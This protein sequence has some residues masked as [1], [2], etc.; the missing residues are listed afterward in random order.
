MSNRC[1]WITFAG[2]ARNACEC[3]CFVLVVCVCVCAQFDL[4]LSVCMCVCVGTLQHA[5]TPLQS[6][7]RRTD[8]RFWRFEQIDRLDDADNAAHPLVVCAALRHRRQSCSLVIYDVP[9]WQ[10]H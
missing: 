6:Q 5:D 10:R 4:S 2:C 8:H 3:G 1:Q 7:L 9:L